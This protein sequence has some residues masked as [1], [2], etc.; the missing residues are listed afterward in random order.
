MR[1]KNSE[2]CFELYRCFHRADAAGGAEHTSGGISGVFRDSLGSDAVLIRLIQHVTAHPFSGGESS[3]VVHRLHHMP[4]LIVFVNR[5]TQQQP[6][7]AVLNA[8][9]FKGGG[10]IGT[11]KALA[12]TNRVTPTTLLTNKGKFFCVSLL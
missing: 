5:G 9:L 11:D 7:R 12:L 4:L 2:A 8:L 3:V 1:R 10:I 6:L